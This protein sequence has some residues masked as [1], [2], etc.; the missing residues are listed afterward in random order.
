MYRKIQYS[1]WGLV[2][3][4]TALPHAVFASRPQ[5]RTVFS[6]H[7]SQWCFNIYIQVVPFGIYKYA[8]NRAVATKT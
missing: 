5:L 8:L 3:Q 7:H 1:G 6:V 4:H 2:P